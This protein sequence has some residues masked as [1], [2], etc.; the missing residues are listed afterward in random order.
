MRRQRLPSP[1]KQQAMLE[2]M[3]SRAKLS[4]VE[5]LALAHI[6]YLQKLKETHDRYRKT[7]YGK[8]Q[9]KRRSKEYYKNVLKPQAEA[10]K[11]MQTEQ[12]HEARRIQKADCKNQPYTRRT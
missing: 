2:E 4:D 9:I 10:R 3:Q 7:E 12:H 6:K 1:E 5:L 11:K 8:V